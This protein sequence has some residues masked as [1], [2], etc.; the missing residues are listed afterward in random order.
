MSSNW[1]RGPVAIAVVI[2]ATGG[3]VVATGLGTT[4][5]RTVVETMTVTNTRTVPGPIRYKIRTKIKKVRVL[6]P[7]ASPSP[8]SQSSPGNSGRLSPAEV[9]EAS[10]DALA[11]AKFCLAVSK[12]GNPS[13]ALVGA[14]ARAHYY[15]PE[16][17]RKDP[18][19]YY[20]FLSSGRRTMRELVGDAANDLARGPYPCEPSVASD[21]ATAIE[22]LPR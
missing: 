3:T 21:F 16:L 10:D 2:A 7:A 6:V 18:D 11:I 19:T 9:K 1:I 13:N 8:S 14:L 12:G 15:L 20:D 5:I 4:K 17:L 22:T